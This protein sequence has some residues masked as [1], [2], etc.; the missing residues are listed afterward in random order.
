MLSLNWEDVVA[1]ASCAWSC[2][3]RGVLKVVQG[4]GTVILGLSL[5]DVA[6]ELVAGSVVWKRKAGFAI[7]EASDSSRALPLGGC[8]RFIWNW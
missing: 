6:V 3:F 7:W 1:F 5:W 2:F 8:C 4:I